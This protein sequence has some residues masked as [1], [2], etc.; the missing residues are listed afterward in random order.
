MIKTNHMSLLSRNYCE[1]IRITEIIEQSVAASGIRNGLVTVLS[2]HTTTGIMV[3]ESLECLE[4]DLMELLGRLA[5]EEYPYAHARMLLD[6]GSTAGNPTGHLKSHLTGNHC[7]FILE[8]GGL[9][10]GEAQ[11]VYFCEFDGPAQRTYLIQ[12]MGD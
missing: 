2:K 4:S 11:D 12:I 10:R 9:V 3:N 7:H 1:F 5:P 6:Y 8:N